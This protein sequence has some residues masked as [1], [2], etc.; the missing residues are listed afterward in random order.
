MRQAQSIIWYRIRLLI[1]RMSLNIK[2]AAL[3]VLAAAS[4]IG[5]FVQAAEITYKKSA[6]TTTPTASNLKGINVNPWFRKPA[7]VG[8]WDRAKPDSWTYGIPPFPKFDQNSFRDDLSSLQLAGF[9]LLRVPIHVGPFMTMDPAQRRA[10]LENIG[11]VLDTALSFKF[12]LLIDYHTSEPGISD[13]LEI[14]KDSQSRNAYISAM[15]DLVEIIGKKSENSIIFET[16]NEP[17]TACND[18]VWPTFQKQIV[19]SVI[20]KFPNTRLAVTGSCYSDVDSFAELRPSD[21]PVDAKNLFF[22]FHYYKPYTFTHQGN[23][24]S[25][26]PQQRYVTGLS[27]PA[28]KG[29]FNT[30][31]NDIL[32]TYKDSDAYATYGEA[33]LEDAFLLARKYYE[34]D[35]DEQSINRDF[36]KISQWAKRNQIPPS[37][38]ILGEFGVLKREGKWFGADV[39]SAA[40]WTKA[41]RGRAEASG[42]AWAMWSYKEGFAL[43]ENE[44]TSTLN[45]LLLDALGLKNT[46]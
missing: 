9:N 16:I 27:W 1:R 14:V 44:D 12:T 34:S 15:L 23:S 42:F 28:S 46:R 17:S 30:A 25:G 4:L 24:W 40:R 38:I 5:I 26:D 18:D 29:N 6:P 13:Y 32:K 35:P 11:T 37:N 36:D 33:P 20:E 39:E 10:A 43:A 21:Y 22:T 7:I 41:V 8:T 3:A 45:P 19:E 31:R 2:A